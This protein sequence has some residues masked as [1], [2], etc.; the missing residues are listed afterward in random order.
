MGSTPISATIPYLNFPDTDTFCYFETFIFKKTQNVIVVRG[1]FYARP[2]IWLHR[3]SVRTPGFQP[4][5]RGF[6]SP[7]SYHNIFAPMV[8]LVDTLVL[9]ASE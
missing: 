3:L 7:W 8:E 1:F 2:L 4:V 9:E 6:N 5:E